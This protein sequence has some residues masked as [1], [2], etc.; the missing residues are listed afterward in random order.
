MKVLVIGNGFDLYHK[1]P[2]TYLAFLETTKFVVSDTEHSASTI[3]SIFDSIKDNCNTV[4]IS[5][6][7]YSK[8]YDKSLLNKE[9][10]EKL[11][12]LCSK[13]KW[14][15]YFCL[16]YRK[17]AGWIDFE[18][19]IAFVIREFESF[20]NRLNVGSKLLIEESGVLSNFDFFI[21]KNKKGT[22]TNYIVD[23]IKDEFM[24]DHRG[25][26]SCVI[27][28]EKIV[29]ALYQD[30]QE[31]KRALDLYLQIF[32][33]APMESIIDEGLIRTNNELFNNADV[34]ID[35]NYTLTYEKLYNNTQAF[36][37]YHIH[38][39][40]EEYLVIG[41]ETDKNDT[42]NGDKLFIDFKKYYQREISSK[43]RYLPG[44]ISDMKR[45]RNIPTG[46]GIV[47]TYVFGHSLDST[48]SDIFIPIFENSDHIHIF[49]HSV[50]AKESQLKNLYRILGKDG[51]DKIR[52]NHGLCFDLAL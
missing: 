19:E 2:T 15:N 27:D 35:F 21:D 6:E 11:S 20:F 12:S 23:H 16:C 1:L 45:N 51:Y 10:I 49:T 3:G 33:D 5:Y 9:M 40:L 25:Y 43:N 4:R 26:N 38:G 39:E 24:N 50:E 13:N 8:V 41:I 48:D 37:P 46:E 36:F 42:A 22:S 14:W 17:D 32:V 30:L 34:I 31:L 28:K 47:D 29:K 7:A 52:D 18:K 44:I